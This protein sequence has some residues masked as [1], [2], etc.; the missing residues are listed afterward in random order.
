[1]CGL[2]KN[3]CSLISEEHPLKP[4]DI[5]AVYLIIALPSNLVPVVHSLTSNPAPTSKDFM[6]TLTQ[7]DTF[8]KT[9]CKAHTAKANGPQTKPRDQHSAKAMPPSD[10]SSNLHCSFCKCDGHDLDFS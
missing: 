3:F 1:M 7:D 5:F 6:H 4:E 9:F 8:V 2:Y 10:N